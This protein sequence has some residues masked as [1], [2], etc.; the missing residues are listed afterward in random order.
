MSRTELE[1]YRQDLIAQGRRLG[2]SSAGIAAEALRGV[3]GMASGSLSNTPLHLADLGTDTYEH[4]ISVGLLENSAVML[5]QIRSALDRI[6][7]GTYG[8]CQ[9]CGKDIPAKRLHALPYTPHCLKCAEQ[10]QSDEDGRL[11]RY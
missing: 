10:V 11:R 3:G 7:D 4:E 9:E 2:L 5:E 8:K 1:E 6:R